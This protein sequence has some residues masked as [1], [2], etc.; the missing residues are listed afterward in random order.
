M[1]LHIF[2]PGVF[3]LHGAAVIDGV[4]NVEHSVPAVRHFRGDLDP[5]ICSVGVVFIGQCAFAINIP[6]DNQVIM[7]RL[8]KLTVHNLFAAACTREHL[9]FEE[10][11]GD[12]N[13]TIRDR[14]RKL[15]LQ[16]FGK[17]VVALAGNDGQHIDCMDI[18]SQ[19]IGVHAPAVLIDAKA[20]AASHFLPFTDFAAALLQRADLEH[21]RVIPAFPQG[22]VRKD[23]ANG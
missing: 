14:I 12:R 19:H 23:K 16:A 21:V 8:R 20:Q 22:G 7:D 10:V 17:A 6:V 4:E 13:R 1:Q 11:C 5:A 3:G 18:V 2:I 15:G 9:A